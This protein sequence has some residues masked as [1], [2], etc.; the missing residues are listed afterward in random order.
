M[1][2]CGAIPFEYVRETHAALFRKAARRHGTHPFTRR[3]NP[4][5]N[6][7]RVWFELYLGEAWRT[8]DA[9]HNE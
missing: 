7:F 4:A 6:G 1:R 3:R 8:Y 5:A 2:C 9:R